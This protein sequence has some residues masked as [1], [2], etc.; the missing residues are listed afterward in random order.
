MKRIN[1]YIWCNKNQ[2]RQYLD[3]F[4]DMDCTWDLL[5]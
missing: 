5:C 2:L 1:I 4:G 3:F